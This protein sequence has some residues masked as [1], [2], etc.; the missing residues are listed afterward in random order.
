MTTTN[1]TH[2]TINLL[3]QIQE[4]HVAR[5]QKRA[6]QPNT[7]LKQ[8]NDTIDSLVEE[9][10][11]PYKD[12]FERLIGRDTM[13]IVPLAGSSCSAC[14]MVLPIG[15][16]NEI[17][18]AETI[19]TCES[20][21]RLLYYPAGLP[22]G[23]PQKRNVT[24]TTG[25]ARFSNPE[26]MI[27]RLEGK[28]AEAVI[29]EMAEVMKERGYIDD[30]AKLTEEALKREALMSTA[31]D[32]GIAFPHVRG[33]E[34]GALTLTLGISK[35]GIKFGGPGGKLT[36]IFFFVTIPMVNSGFY[37]KLLAGLCNAFDDKDARELL[38]KQEDPDALWDVLVKT[39]KLTIK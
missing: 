11:V 37:I 31:V 23:V 5:V 29:A 12:Q 15:R 28:T 32:N 22:K 35:K 34:G 9:I 3:I 2:R 1:H 27:A 16:V 26:L 20:C 30:A 8:L 38:S 24:P 21:A 18:T 17:R 14:G 7:R 19:Y 36:R 4:L 10:P 6:T 39:T 13:A 33:V 25:I